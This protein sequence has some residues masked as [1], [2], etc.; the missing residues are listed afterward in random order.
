MFL[1]LTLGFHTAIG[2][3]CLLCMQD[4]VP[5][6]WWW[7]VGLWWG[8]SLLASNGIRLYKAMRFID[9]VDLLLE[10][11]KWA[12]IVAS[13][14]LDLPFGSWPSLGFVFIM[15]LGLLCF[16]GLGLG[17]KLGCSVYGPCSKSKFNCAGKWNIVNLRQYIDLT[18]CVHALITRQYNRWKIKLYKLNMEIYKHRYS[19]RKSWFLKLVNLRKSDTRF[20]L[21]QKWFCRPT[22]RERGIRSAA[23]FRS[24]QARRCVWEVA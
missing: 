21:F 4:W 13:I 8:P 18:L 10:D 23:A 22:W 11:S 24:C 5:P 9:A 12:A 19:T 7:W 2:E 3:V 1:V 20:L 17:L 14:S 15:P 16:I 6:P